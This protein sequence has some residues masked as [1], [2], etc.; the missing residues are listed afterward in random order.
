MET[1]T[2]QYADACHF[3]LKKEFK[4]N[5]ELL[6]EM[7]CYGEPRSCEIYQRYAFS[8]SVPK[9]FCPVGAYQH[10]PSQNR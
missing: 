9:N 5:I 8:R 3:F 4:S 1:V 10:S 7:Y 2:C 6:R